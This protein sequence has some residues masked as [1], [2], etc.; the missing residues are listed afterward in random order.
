MIVT[1]ATVP[2]S[3]VALLLAA[4]LMTA[5]DQL[6][7]EENDWYINVNPQEHPIFSYG[8]SGSPEEQLEVNY[9]RSEKTEKH[10]IF[11]Y[12]RSGSPEEEPDLSSDRSGSPEEEY[13]VSGSPEYGEYNSEEW[14]ESNRPNSKSTRISDS[15]EYSDRFAEMDALGRKIPVWYRPD[16]PFT[17]NMSAGSIPSPLARRPDDF[18]DYPL[19]EIDPPVVRPNFNTQASSLE[20][21]RTK[22]PQDGTTVDEDLFHDQSSESTVMVLLID[23]CV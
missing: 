13:D 9:S 4:V 16:R 3:C 2:I 22:S 7:S 20:Q 15:S 11:S 8:T 1:M 23:W 14:D 6:D 12:G 5:G 19:E 18:Y 10:P 21:S 17:V